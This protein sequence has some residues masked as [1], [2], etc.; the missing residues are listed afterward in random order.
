[1]SGTTI[2]HAL[3]NRF[4]SIRLNEIGRLEKKLRGLSAD[5]RRKAEAIIGEVVHAIARL[6]EHALNDDTPAPALQALVQLFE[7]DADPSVAPR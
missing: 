1:M 5:E 3:R 2:G 6:P 4:D 7:L